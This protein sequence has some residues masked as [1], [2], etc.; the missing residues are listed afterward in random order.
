MPPAENTVQT[1]N[2]AS[3]TANDTICLDSD[4]EET[5]TPTVE[6]IPKARKV[7]AVKSTAKR[8]ISVPVQSAAANPVH[9]EQPQIIP[10]LIPSF[11]PEDITNLVQSQNIGPNV[12]VI[13]ATQASKLTKLP[14]GVIPA[15]VKNISRI[16]VGSQNS[17]ISMQKPQNVSTLNPHVDNLINPNNVILNQIPQNVNL[18]DRTPQKPFPPQNVNLSTAPSFS[19]ISAIPN[20]TAAPQMI[21]STKVNTMPG[22]IKT[23]EVTNQ[24]VNNSELILPTH[25]PTTGPTPGPASSKSGNKT[26]CKP[27]DILRITKSGQVEILNRDSKKVGQCISTTST[28]QTEEPQTTVS[29]S[30]DDEPIISSKIKN[31]TKKLKRSR[32]VSSSSSSS[33]NSSRPPSP[34]DPLAILK[35]VVHIQATEDPIESTKSN[36]PSEKVISSVPIKKSAL[37]TTF[38]T[39]RTPNDSVR[40]VSQGKKDKILEQINKTNTALKKL[41]DVLGPSERK[42]KKQNIGKLDSVDLTDATSPSI[43]LDKLSKDIKIGKSSKNVTTTIVG[44]SKNIILTG[45]GKATVTSED[46]Q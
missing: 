36:L 10:E 27:G 26:V 6:P 1:P 34:K 29:L 7:V 35:D 46:N 2:V 5:I 19:M 11:L 24:N 22:S 39:T 18:V 9:G 3:I 41:N 37:S 12:V 32:K 31:K 13:P 8:Q 38:K 17:A 42:A 33:S 20:V 15:N 25:T 14:Q 45:N 40:N 30:D 23:A 28:K 44:T 4:E 16:F 21:T 43:V